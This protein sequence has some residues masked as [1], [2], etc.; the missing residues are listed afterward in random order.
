MVVALGALHARAL[1]QVMVI[2]AMV[3][4]SGYPLLIALHVGIAL[5]QA[6]STAAHSARPIP[7]H[8]TRFIPSLPR[9]DR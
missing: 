7:Q 8:S 2:A 6:H 5:A 9:T 4:L 1:L 3:R